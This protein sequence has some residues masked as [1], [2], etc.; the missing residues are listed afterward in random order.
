MLLSVARV[1]RIL[2]GSSGSIF[3]H[4]IRGFS[5]KSRLNRD[6]EERQKKLESLSKRYTLRRIDVL[7]ESPA[8]QTDSTTLHKVRDNIANI[9]SRVDSRITKI[10]NIEALDREELLQTPIGTIPLAALASVTMSGPK[11]ATVVAHDRGNIDRIFKALKHA[12]AHCSCSILGRE[13]VEVKIPR[14][15]P[16]VRELRG[17]QVSKLIDE[18]RK[19]LKKAELLVYKE[20]KASQK[21]PTHATTSLVERVKVEFS[22]ATK[23]LDDALVAAIDKLGLE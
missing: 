12:F 14:I 1:S 7:D 21:G 19:E 3:S 17:A 22:T 13:R 20:I 10:S 23:L 16:E 9:L 18:S 8:P 5:W 4:K 2:G 11:S 6:P 15:T